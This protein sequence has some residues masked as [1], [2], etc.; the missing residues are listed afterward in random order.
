MKGGGGGG[1]GGGVVDVARLG[2]TDHG[3]DENV[4]MV[5]PRRAD[6]QL[7]MSSVHRVPGLEGNHSGPS[8]LIEVKSQ[9]GR[10]I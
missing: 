7:P 10:G 5:G 1:G 2:E 4:G 6:R 3:V 8:K 9:F